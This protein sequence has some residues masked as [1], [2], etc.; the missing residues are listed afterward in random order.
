MTKWGDR[1][2]WEFAGRYLGADEHGDWVGFPAGSHFARPGAAFVSP[3]DQVTLLPRDGAGWVATFHAAGGPVRAYVDVT[4]TPVWE[5]VVVS[6]VDLDLDVI[7][8]LDGT[9]V[10]DDEDEFAE[11]Q[12]AFGYP[13]EVIASARLAC[14]RVRAEVAARRPPYD[15]ATPARWL[16][17]LAVPP[18][19][20]H[21]L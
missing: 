8:R 4:T 21:T 11:H 5:G 10:V 3:V 17:V 9:V 19:S 1:P 2:H 6:L 20:P 13:P 7:E 14:D 18:P 16:T 12:V 15:L